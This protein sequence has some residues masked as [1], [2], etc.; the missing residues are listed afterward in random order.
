MGFDLVAICILTM[1]LTSTNSIFLWI[2]SQEIAL[3]FCL[4]KYEV[5]ENE[6]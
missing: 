5:F 3:H 1:G 6:K 2:Y 4:H